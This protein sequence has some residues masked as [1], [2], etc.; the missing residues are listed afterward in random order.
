MARTERPDWIMSVYGP[1]HRKALG[2][3]GQ[4]VRGRGALRA[5]RRRM[6]HEDHVAR[7]GGG[8]GYSLHGF[9][10]RLR[11][12]RAGGLLAVRTPQRAHT[13]ARGSAP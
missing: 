3:H 8:K 2:H 11:S 13:G 12:L 4:S 10:T 9:L 5:A 7:K 6:A 1:F